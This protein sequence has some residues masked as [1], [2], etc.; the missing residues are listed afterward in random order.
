M[1]EDSKELRKT[2]TARD[3]CLG[4]QSTCNKGPGAAKRRILAAVV[5]CL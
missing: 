4:L 5:T 1:T 3:K 2:T